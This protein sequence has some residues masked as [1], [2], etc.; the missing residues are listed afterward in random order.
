M[1]I[2]KIA[3]DKSKEVEGIWMPFDDAELLIASNN[4]QAYKRALAK[5]SKGVKSFMLKAEPGLSEKIVQKAMATAVLL[6]F[7]NI[8]QGGKPLVNS[9]E[10][11]MLLLEQKA[12]LNFVAEISE[13][14]TNFQAE[15]T[16]EGL[17]TLKSSSE[18][19]IEPRA[20]H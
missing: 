12:I 19:G 16:Q 3:T 1:D 7:K 13:D 11:R 17:D 6:D 20:E 10:N 14:F 2:D 9:F 15:A 4:T 8:N 18:V 5:F